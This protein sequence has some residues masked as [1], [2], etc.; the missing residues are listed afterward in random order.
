MSTTVGI[1]LLLASLMIASI[2]VHARLRYGS[3]DDADERDERA[4]R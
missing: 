1:L 4:Q 2:I 3:H